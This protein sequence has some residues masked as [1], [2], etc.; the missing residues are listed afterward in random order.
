VQ[1]QIGLFRVTAVDVETWESSAP[2]NIKI[3]QLKMRHKFR[4]IQIFDCNYCNFVVMTKPS[5]GIS[6][7]RVRLY[8]D[9][10]FCKLLFHRSSSFVMK[11]VLPEMLTRNIMDKPQN[12]QLNDETLSK[13]YMCEE[14]EYGKMIF[15]DSADCKIGWFHY[16]CT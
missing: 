7:V 11:H 3:Y 10:D 15:C 2:L 14:S 4:Q 9:S 1:Q 6:M 8:K 5:S 12:D 13:W 16:P